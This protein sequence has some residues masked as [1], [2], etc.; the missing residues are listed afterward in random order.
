MGGRVIEPREAIQSLAALRL[1]E[2]TVLTVVRDASACSWP[3]AHGAVSRASGCSLVP[4]GV[5]LLASTG[6]FCE[7]RV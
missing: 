7:P 1:D 4:R 6:G 2:A 3:T 5:D